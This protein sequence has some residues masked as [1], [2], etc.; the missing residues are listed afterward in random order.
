L[1]ALLLPV[2]T[3]AKKKSKRTSCLSNIKPLGMAMMVIGGENHRFGPVQGETP[4]HQLDVS[5]RRPATI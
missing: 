1:A 4:F 2:L 5:L 3:V